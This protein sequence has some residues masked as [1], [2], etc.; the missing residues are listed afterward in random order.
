MSAILIGVAIV[1]ALLQRDFI[2]AVS[3]RDGVQSRLAERSAGLAPGVSMTQALRVDAGYYLR[4]LRRRQPERE[5]ERKRV[6]ALAGLAAAI[7]CLAWLL[8]APA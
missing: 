6:L 2:A 1:A 7:A 3:G 5:I 4:Q 8:F